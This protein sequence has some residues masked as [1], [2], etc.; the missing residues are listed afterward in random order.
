L[1]NEVEQMKEILTEKEQEIGSLKRDLA[2]PHES[3][4][5]VSVLICVLMFVI[6]PLLLL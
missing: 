2:K 1:Q 4:P 3:S 5:K 6:N